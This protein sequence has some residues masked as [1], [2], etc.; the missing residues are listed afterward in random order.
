MR[1]KPT[2]EEQTT[3]T[4]NPALLQWTCH[5]VKHKP[6]LLTVFVVLFLTLLVALT[7]HWTESG[8]FTLVV[9]LVLWGSLSQYFLPVSFSFNELDVSVKYTTH[10]ITKGWNLFRSYYVDK[11][12]VLLSPFVRPSRLENF[13]GLYIR[14]SGNK[15]E[16]LAIVKD[17]IRIV[18]DEV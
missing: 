1:E 5:P 15:N 6:I 18:E 9:A 14:F 16:V 2:A 3:T 13:R 7:Y 8:L 10:K 12:G 17:K 11:N 4:D